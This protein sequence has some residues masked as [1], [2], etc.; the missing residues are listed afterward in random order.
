MQPDTL[1]AKQL[2]YFCEVN[3]ELLIAMLLASCTNIRAMIEAYSEP[4]SELCTPF[5]KRS[6]WQSPPATVP[7]GYHVAKPEK[8]GGGGHITA[9]VPYW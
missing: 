5:C 4:T 1:E 9:L 2:A 8:G 6:R 7:P 3:I